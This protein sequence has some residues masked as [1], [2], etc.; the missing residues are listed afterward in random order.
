MESLEIILRNLYLFA[1]I[2]GGGFLIIDLLGLL[3]SGDGDADAGDADA[4]NV[5][6]GEVDDVGGGEGIGRGIIG[7]LRYIR[8]F[9]YFC[10][11]FGPTGLAAG[12]F[13]YGTGSKFLWALGT[14]AIVAVI[15]RALFRFQHQDLDSTIAQHE[16][17][18]ERAEVTVPISGGKMGKVRLRVGVSVVEKFAVAAEPTDSFARGALVRIIETN[19]DCVTV[20]PYDGSPSRDDASWDEI[21][22][23]GD[24]Q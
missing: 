5:D 2:F 20:E 9:I 11:G 19:N 10:A 14:G 24:V 3:D 6:A 13:G 18:A 15:A 17:L 1:T 22:R 4:G 8:T 7:I 21:D 16:L 23:E 12:L